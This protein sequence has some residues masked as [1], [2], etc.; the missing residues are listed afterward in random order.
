MIINLGSYC[1]LVS[2][3][4]IFMNYNS[5]IDLWQYFECMMFDHL[6]NLQDKSM[7]KRFMILFHYSK[8]SIPS[9]AILDYSCFVSVA[10]FSEKYK[11]IGNTISRKKLEDYLLGAYIILGQ[12]YSVGG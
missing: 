1:E 9:E 3:I 5:I 8:S 12:Y 11:N 4:H 2:P 10:S 7:S 6:L